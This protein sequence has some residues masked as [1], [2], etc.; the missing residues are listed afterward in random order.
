[1]SAVLLDARHIVPA[2]TP[3][4]LP[5]TRAGAAGWL[6][7]LLLLGS[8]SPTDSHKDAKGSSDVA[9][10]AQGA[11]P[12]INDRFRADDL[13][14]AEYVLRFE[15]ESR[16]IAVCRDALVAALELSPG[17]DLADV[18]AG[19][20]LF[21]APFHQAVG[22]DG[23]V[24]AVDISEGFLAFMGQRISEEG[25]DRVTPVLCDDRTTGLPAA[26]VDVVFVCDTYHHFEYPMDT[27]ASIHAAL[28]PG[29]RMVIV[30]FERIPGVTRDWLL[31][32]VRCDKQT[33]IDEVTAAGFRL[34]AE[35]PLE[36]LSEN[37]VLRFS[38]N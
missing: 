8:C 37:Y 30:D 19:T 3:L 7:L 33:V 16:E 20:G 22:P 1:M 15:G 29:G 28:R 25:L 10:A 17:E 34:D 2:R 12:S 11:D 21:L 23:Q 38:R 27:L 14:V 5:L 36:G 13:D 35:L 4:G 24:F 18:G 6:A 26:S 9:V 31:E 32:H